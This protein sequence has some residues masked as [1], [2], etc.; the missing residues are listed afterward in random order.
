MNILPVVAGLVLLF[1]VLAAAVVVLYSLLILQQKLLMWALLVQESYQ[2]F[3]LQSV[4]LLSLLEFQF[5]LQAF[6]A[7]WSLLQ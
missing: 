6:Q 2:G 4:V 1:V 7:L 3:D 5:H